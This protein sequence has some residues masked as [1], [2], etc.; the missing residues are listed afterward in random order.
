VLAQVRTEYQKLDS[1]SALLHHK[2]SSGLYPGE[3]YQQ[4][5]WKKGNRFE[6]TWVQPKRRRPPK[7]QVPNFYA[8]TINV[9]LVMPDLTRSTMPIISEPNTM[10]G[11]EVAGG[12][13]L[14][15]LQA[16]PS[17]DLIESPPT[18]LGVLMTYGT[19]TKWRG[20]SVVEVLTAV[21]AGGERM[22]VSY[23]VSPYLNR[24]IGSEWR[25]G[26]RAGWIHYTKQ[27]ANP[28]LPEKL[29]ETPP[30]QS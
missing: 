23:F 21:G 24:L 5:N 1:F 6:L 18:S 30:Q 8:D 17:V 3:H 25:Q 4:L 19:R 2:N 13:I 12:P 20:E 10:P 27:I 16:T 7:R 29:G 15:W 14:T 26:K 9:N 28:E 11:W 22:T